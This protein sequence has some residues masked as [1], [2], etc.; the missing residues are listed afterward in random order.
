[1]ETRRT[2]ELDGSPVPGVIPEPIRVHHDGV[3]THRGSF[4]APPPSVATER[5]APWRR[6]PVTVLLAKLSAVRGDKH[7]AVAY[8]PT[9]ARPVADEAVEPVPDNAGQ[10]A[11]A[12]SQTKER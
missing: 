2:I 4:P 7:P 12:G 6:N 8:P 10:P 1:M 5:A 9:R 11:T 3:P